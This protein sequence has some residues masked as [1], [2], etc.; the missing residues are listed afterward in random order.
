MGIAN[1]IKLTVWTKTKKPK[2]GGLAE[3]DDANAGTQYDNDPAYIAAKERFVEMISD[4]TI[5]YD[6]A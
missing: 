5:L 6:K 2:K 1:P 3:Y 4:P